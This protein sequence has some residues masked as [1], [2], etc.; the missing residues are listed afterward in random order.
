MGRFGTSAAWSGH[1]AASVMAR[2]LPS[3]AC[4]Q[5]VRASALVE[6]QMIA[7]QAVQTARFERAVQAMLKQRHPGLRSYDGTGGDGGK[8]A[9]LVTADGAMCSR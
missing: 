4:D 9:R 6:R 5:P 1:L 8:D 7:W 3:A 2:A